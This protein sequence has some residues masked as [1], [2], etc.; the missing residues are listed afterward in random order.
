[1]LCVNVLNMPN[2]QKHYYNMSVLLIDMSQY[3]AYA[4]ILYKSNDNK[5]ML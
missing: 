5:D 4:I 3:N 1:M 2:D